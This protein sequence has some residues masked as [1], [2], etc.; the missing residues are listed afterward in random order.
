MTPDKKDFTL[1]KLRYKDGIVSI[2]A[3]AE[4]AE[5]DRIDT[6]KIDDDF[7]FEPHEDLTSPL[8]KL[9]DALASCH[10]HKLIETL[11]MS[12]E[13]KATPAQKKSVELALESELMDIKV[14]GI[15]ISGQDQNRGCVISGSYDGQ[16]INSKRI[17]LSPTSQMT[18]GFEDVVN[19]A[20]DL[21]IDEAFKYLYEQKR[22]EVT[23]LTDAAQT[24]I[25]D[26][27]DE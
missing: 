25:E 14:S 4:F 21:I 26:T 17:K 18:L 7:T 23:V 13:F 1:S 11:V 27:S 20:C 12:T 22:G 8:L 10:G 3:K 19:E 16:A 6:Q 5:G 15:S 24:D 9:K 2:I